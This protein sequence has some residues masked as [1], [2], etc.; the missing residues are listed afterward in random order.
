MLL[1]EERRAGGVLSGRP[2]DI[3]VE[4]SSGIQSMSTGS[5][6]SVGKEKAGGTY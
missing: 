2:G 3:D 4:S 6:V 1:L 5:C